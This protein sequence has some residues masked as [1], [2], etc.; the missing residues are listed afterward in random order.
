MVETVKGR[1]IIGPVIL[2]VAGIL[3][4]ITGFLVALQV[5]GIAGPGDMYGTLAPFAVQAAFGIGVCVGGYILL[6]GDEI[7]GQGAL[8][9]GLIELLLA[10][11]V[12]PPPPSFIPYV[13]YLMIWG[14]VILILV[15]RL[16]GLALREKKEQEGPP[17]DTDFSQ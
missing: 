2:M 13:F 7:G 6:R 10:T 8:I 3:P 1:A 15:G 4:F 9:A 12:L 11:F 14:D 5:P 16:V 17:R